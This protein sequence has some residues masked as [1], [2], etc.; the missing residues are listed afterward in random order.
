MLDFESMFRAGMVKIL[1]T[2][3]NSGIVPHEA[4]GISSPG[5]HEAI[6]CGLAKMESD[7][8]GLYWARRVVEEDIDLCGEPGGISRASRA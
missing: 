7:N 3:G 2:W 1:A 5:R 6:R 8:G 4:Q